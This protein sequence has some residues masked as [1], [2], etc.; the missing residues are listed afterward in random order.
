MSN[1]FDSNPVFLSVVIRDRLKYAHYFVVSF[2]DY[3]VPDFNSRKTSLLENNVSNGSSEVPASLPVDRECV[4]LKK[5]MKS[6]L[7][8]VSKA[9][10]TPICAAAG[11]G[12][13]VMLRTLTTIRTC[14]H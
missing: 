11:F 13:R 3:N 6:L 8:I 9:G 12:T 2:V 4:F 14:C 1:V 5:S 7:Y 10:C